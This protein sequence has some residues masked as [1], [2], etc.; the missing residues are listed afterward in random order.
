MDSDTESVTIQNQYNVMHCQGF[1]KIKI[2][3]KFSKRER[4][5]RARD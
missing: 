1:N 5:G 3:F 4:G 2:P